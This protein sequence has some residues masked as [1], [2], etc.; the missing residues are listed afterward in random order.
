MITIPASL[1]ENSE[2]SVRNNGGEL[3]KCEISVT[4]KSK[5]YYFCNNR[6]KEKFKK[7]RLKDD[8]I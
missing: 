4:K 1:K 2:S 5:T 3:T 8:K 7:G 6:V